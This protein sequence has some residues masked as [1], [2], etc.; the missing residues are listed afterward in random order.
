MSSARLYVGNDIS[1][2]TG[3]VYSTSPALSH[4]PPHLDPGL[5]ETIVWMR[6][7]MKTHTVDPDGQYLCTVRWNDGVSDQEWNVSLQ[8]LLG[9]Y[10]ETPM[11]IWCDASRNLTVQVKPLH[12][13]PLVVGTV[14]V[15]LLGAY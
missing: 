4:D 15:V 7:R 9:S 1:S 8:T 13:D 14:D 6:V 10:I 12:T 3:E 5:S 2:D 11:D